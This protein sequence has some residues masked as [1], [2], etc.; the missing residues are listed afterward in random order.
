LDSIK[1]IIIKELKI[2]VSMKTLQ[3]AFVSANQ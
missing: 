1:N 3:A 2:M